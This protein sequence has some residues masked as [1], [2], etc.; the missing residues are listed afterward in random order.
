MSLLPHRL[1][2]RHPPLHL[3]FRGCY[4]STNFGDDL[5]LLGLLDALHRSVGLQPED[6]TIWIDPQQDSIPALKYPLP[7]KLNA[8][9]EPLKGWN[10]TLTSWNLNGLV[11][12]L[13]LVLGIV[14]F[15]FQS[16]TSS[17]IKA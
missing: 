4:N 16:V 1:S 9:H 3:Y 11:R 17:W 6:T 15:S 12:K 14:Y 8:F 5:L 7:F 13:F 2:Q 10:R